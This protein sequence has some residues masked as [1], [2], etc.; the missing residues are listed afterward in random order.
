MDNK[1]SIKIEQLKEL[2]AL[3]LS[4]KFKCLPE[5]ICMGDY[6]AR[7]TDDTVCPYKVIMGYANFEGSQVKSLGNLQVVFG[8][9]LEDRGGC[10]T[11]IDGNPSYLGINLFNSKIISLE[12]L[13]KVYGS[14]TL[15]ENIKSLENLK[16]LG[17]NLFLANTK[18]ED[19][20][21]LE[22]VDGMLNFEKTTINSLGKIKRIGKLRIA[23]QSLKSFGDLERVKE[24]VV[25][26]QPRYRFD[27]LINDTFVRSGNKYI[28][29]IE[30]TN[31]Q[32]Q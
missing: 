15:N 1:M 8:K 10:L 28:R 4:K 2:S 22:V 12:K 6:I 27:E 30:Q 32:E 17:S 14:I 7:H 11:D 13:E 20:G 25:A 26:T 9:R 5:E 3:E 21:N 23:C 19:L 24:I 29:I 31:E 16:F 18:L